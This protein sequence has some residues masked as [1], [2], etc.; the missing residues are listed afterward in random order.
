LDGVGRLDPFADHFIRFAVV[1]VS[2]VVVGDAGNLDVQVDAVE[3]R[4]GEAGAEE[5]HDVSKEENI[6]DN[7]KDLTFENCENILSSLL[8]VFYF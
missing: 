4:A 1:G 6:K 5:D 8:T 3:E 7:I 2:K